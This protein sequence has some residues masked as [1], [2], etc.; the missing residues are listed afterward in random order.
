MSFWVIAPVPYLVDP[1]ADKYT[2][3]STWAELVP[4]DFGYVDKCGT[5]EDSRFKCKRVRNTG[6]LRQTI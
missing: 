2:F 4:V 1:I 5:P 6:R 3:L